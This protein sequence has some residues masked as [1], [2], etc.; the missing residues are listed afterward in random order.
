MKP[1]LLPALT[2]AYLGDSVFEV[3]VREFLIKECHIV[4]PNLLQKEAVQYVSAKAQA[5]FMQKAIECGWL[6]DEEIIIY[7]RGRNAKGRRHVKNMSV[8]THNQS[9]GFETLIGHLYL[10]DNMSRIQE[11]FELYKGYVDGECL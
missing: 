8:I 6:S 5:G 11:I 7:K 9:S 4:K 2:V 10:L 1:E 3:Y